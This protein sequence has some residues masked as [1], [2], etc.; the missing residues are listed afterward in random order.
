[1]RG[2]IQAALVLSLDN[3]KPGQKAAEEIAA[4]LTALGVFFLQANIAGEHKDPNDRLQRDKAG[5]QAAIK[6]AAAEG[7]K[8]PG[9]RSTGRNRG[10]QAGKRGKPY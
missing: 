4:E 8:S 7:C 3:D 10:I 6:E 5:L 9:H 2:L 1:M